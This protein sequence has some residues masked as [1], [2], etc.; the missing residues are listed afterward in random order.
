M[1][2]ACAAL[3]AR[4]VFATAARLAFAGAAR[5][6]FASAATLA[7]VAQVRARPPHN[8]LDA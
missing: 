6:A 5:L 7:T 2:S 1:R 8:T 4:L 3:A